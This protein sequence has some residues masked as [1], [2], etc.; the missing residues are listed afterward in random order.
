MV[1]PEQ[2]ISERA[3]QAG[4]PMRRVAGDKVHG[5]STALRD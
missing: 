3:W 1:K 2:A 4:V 5:D